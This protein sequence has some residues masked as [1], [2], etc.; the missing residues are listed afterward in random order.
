MKLVEYFKINGLFSAEQWNNKIPEGLWNPEQIS[1]LSQVITIFLGFFL[2]A[3]VF[4]NAKRDNVL[5][6]YIFMNSSMIIWTIGLAIENTCNSGTYLTRFGPLWVSYLG[7]CTMGPGWLVFCMF[8][9]ENEWVQKR[10]NIFL[11]FIPHFAF[12]F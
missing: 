2:I 1:S 8:L 11:L 3:F 9:T 10:K 12:Y 6:S 4:H 7:I 5:K